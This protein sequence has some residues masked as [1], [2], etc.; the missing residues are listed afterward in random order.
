M[1][2]RPTERMRRRVLV[3]LTLILAIVVGYTIWCIFKI[4][5][6]ESKK[7]QSLANSQQLTS[8]KI[9]RAHV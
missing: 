7:W 9:G 6:K 2:D 1:I 5:I 4:S 3:W 8:T